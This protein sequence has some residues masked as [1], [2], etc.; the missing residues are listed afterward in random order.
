MWSLD[1]KTQKKFT[2]GTWNPHQ[3]CSQIATANDT[4]IR[5][6]DLRSQKY[7]LIVYLY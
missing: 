5:G 6:W 4:C 1:S 2:I 3:N 7:T